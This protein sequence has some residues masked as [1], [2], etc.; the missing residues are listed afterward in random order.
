[1]R[2]LRKIIALGAPCKLKVLSMTFLKKINHNK[3]HKKCQIRSKKTKIEINRLLAQKSALQHKIKDQES[4]KKKSAN[5]EVN[6]ARR[7]L[8]LTS[9]LAIC[10][11]E[12]GEDLQLDHPDKSATLLRFF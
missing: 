5:Q 2:F 3:N 10:K 11:I 12:L 9:S 6:S 4:S 8:D 1:M 7:G